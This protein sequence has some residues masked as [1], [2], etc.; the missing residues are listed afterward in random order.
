MALWLVGCGANATADAGPGPAGDAGEARGD[1]G[2]SDAGGAADGGGRDASAG[3]DPCATIAGVTYETVSPTGDPPD[4]P[5]AEHGDLNLALRGW[6][7][8]GG[9]LGLIDVPGPTDAMAP[10]LNTLFVDDRVPSFTTNYRVHH[11]DWGCDCRG[12]PIE[13]W[14]VTLAG[15]GTARGE[16]LELPDS[17]YDIGGGYDAMVLFVDDASITFEYTRDDSVARGYA[18]HV[19]GVC[20]EPSLR[21]RYEASHTAGRDELPALTGNQPFGRARG[22]EV[23]VAIRDSGSFMDPRVEKDWW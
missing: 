1:G 4:R 7:P 13:D 19:D 15:F 5:P 14:E 16:V 8:T 23:R 9:T 21:A 22:D 10:K 2:R 3:P 11:W 17:G 6:A 20:V 18:I 12:G